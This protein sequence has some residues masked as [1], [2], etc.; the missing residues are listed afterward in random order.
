[1][2]GFAKWLTARRVK[3]WSRRRVR[4]TSEG[5]ETHDRRWESAVA[6][7]AHF[8]VN[9][10]QNDLSADPVA[11]FHLGNGASLHAIH[12]GTGFERARA[13]TVDGDHGQ[14]LYDL[15]NIEE[16]HDAYFDEGRVAR[17]KTVNRLL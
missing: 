1:M 9:E 14:L 7:C 5:R 16:N 2:P 10:R 13:Q 15:D 4:S 8:L 12:W 3:R 17:S 11:R 6:V